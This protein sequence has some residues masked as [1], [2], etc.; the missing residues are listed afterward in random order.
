MEVSHGR[1]RYF[2]VTVLP[3]SVEIV[4]EPGVK[5]GGSQWFIGWLVCYCMGVSYGD[6]GRIQE[7]FSGESFF[8]HPPLLQRSTVWHVGKQLINIEWKVRTVEIIRGL[9]YGGAMNRWKSHGRLRVKLTTGM[10]GMSI[11][12]V[13]RSVLLWHSGTKFRCHKF[14]T[15][16]PV[17][18]DRREEIK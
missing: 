3:F 9:I 2:T 11:I 17:P 6:L 15:N 10:P 14:E 18:D 5:T 16:E 13:C 12:V 1:P 7:V 4:Y 8:S